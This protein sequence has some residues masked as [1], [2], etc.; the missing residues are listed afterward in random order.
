M[1]APDIAPAAWARIAAERPFL[2]RLARAQLTCAADAEDV[3]QEALVSALLG[4][5][6][7]RDAAALRSWLVGI[8]RHKVTDLLRRRRLAPQAF[9]H[10]ESD[11]DDEPFDNA[12][13]WHP[14]ALAG[15]AGGE[16]QLMRRQLGRALEACAAELP[17]PAAQLLLLRELV[18]LEMDELPQDGTTQGALRVRLHRARHRMRSCLLRS[19]GAPD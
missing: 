10:M 18:G 2:L 19:W 11:S 16:Q 1:T 9:P 17:S 3:V 13:A 15:M 5:S 12:A 8:L 6:T 7:L 4:W 14:A